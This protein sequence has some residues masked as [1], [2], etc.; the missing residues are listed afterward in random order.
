MYRRILDYGILCM[1]VQMYVWIRIY[2]YQC[3][4]YIHVTLTAQ[5]WSP[6]EYR[7]VLAPRATTVPET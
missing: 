3:D 5:T 6:T 7:V 2:T 1:C 4:A